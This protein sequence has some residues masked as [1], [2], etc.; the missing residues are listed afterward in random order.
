[1]IHVVRPALKHAGPSSQSELSPPFDGSR[2]LWHHRW[3]DGDPF[4]DPTL[5]DQQ[6]DEMGCEPAMLIRIANQ[7]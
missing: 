3:T 6:F 7:P 4:A 1:M 5:L 2:P